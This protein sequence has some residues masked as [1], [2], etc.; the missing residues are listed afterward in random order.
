MLPLPLVLRPLHGF[1]RRLL[2]GG[3]WAPAH[4][5]YDLG[6]L[7]GLRQGPRVPGLVAEIVGLSALGRGG[8]AGPPAAAGPAVLLRE[9][10]VAFSTRTCDLQAPRAETGDPLARLRT[11][12]CILL[13]S[14]SQAPG[15]AGA[16]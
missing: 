4:V 14:T 8:L 15:L 3:T 1:A 16:G 2:P 12:C 7:L 6:P 5:V 13:R 11:A 9:Q 10:L